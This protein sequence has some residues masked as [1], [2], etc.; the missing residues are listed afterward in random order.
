LEHR[1]NAFLEKVL[2][3]AVLKAGSPFYHTTKP[4]GSFEK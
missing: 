1:L 4:V 3:E 2:E